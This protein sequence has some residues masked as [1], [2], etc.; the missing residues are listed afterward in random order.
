MSKCYFEDSV[1]AH[2]HVGPFERCARCGKTICPECVGRHISS[3]E[4]WCF[5]CATVSLDDE[6][7]TRYTHR[8]PTRT[9]TTAARTIRLRPATHGIQRALSRLGHSGLWL[10]GTGIL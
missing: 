6:R 7:L 5:R 9:Y 2:A 8:P 4:V 3:R 10:L 1:S